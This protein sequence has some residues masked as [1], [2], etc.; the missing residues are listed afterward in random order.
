M[1]ELDIP[2]A[3]LEVYLH[4]L[5]LRTG[6]WA[7][8]ARRIVWDRQLYD[9]DDETLVLLL[10]VLLAW[11]VGVLRA[12]ACSGLGPAW[13]D[14]LAALGDEHEHATVDSH[15]AP[16]LVLQDA[17]DRAE[18]R[19]LAD[20]LRSRPNPPARRERPQAQVVFGIDVRSEVFRGVPRCSEVFRRH[21]EATATDIETIG[22][23]GFFG[24]SLDYVPLAHD[25]GEAQCPVLLTPGHTVLEVVDDRARVEDVVA[26]RRLCHHVRRSWKS[27]K[28]GAISCF[29]FVRPVG[30]IYLPKM[31]T[32][33]FG[34]TRPVAGPT[35]EGL[36]TW[37]VD[38]R[39]P[40]LSSAGSGSTV[41]GISLESRIQ[42][43]E[44]ALR[45][46]SLTD[47]FAP[48]VVIT[49][50]GATT[51][52]NPY[53]RRLACGAC[54]GHTGEAN[55]RVAATV[56]NDPDVRAALSDPGIEIPADTWFLAA[57]HDTTAD[58]VTLFD[59]AQLP[60]RTSPS[61][62]TWPASSPPPARTAEPIGCPG[63]PSPPLPPS[64]PT[65]PSSGAVPTGPRSAPTGASPAAA[66]SS[67]RPG[68][69][70][71]ASTWKGG[72][73]CTP[74]TGAKTAISRSSC[75]S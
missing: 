45:G 25:R 66:P 36:Q 14:G 1:A 74:T 4:V 13:T 26:H 41:T 19:R 44:G 62:P 42:L 10:A 20:Q 68:T 27:F 8:H 59:Q 11:E 53:D 2:P 32:D 16:R 22:F 5:L 64:P 55:A 3:G 18:H 60:P 72:R 30:L 56:L 28:M 67:P 12:L 39:V 69:A 48:L 43:A 7:A 58:G 65:A 73:S 37:A 70:G 24:F 47:G 31:L 35:D 23:A 50:H 63:S 6:G 15:L 71:R 38:H 75:S 29:S 54:G 33:T 34:T 51:V 61:S 49:G 46:M 9:E 40:A 52:N 21:L 57:Q 17:F